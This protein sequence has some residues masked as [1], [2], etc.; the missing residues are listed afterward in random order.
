MLGNICN[1]CNKAQP[2]TSY[3]SSKLD[4]RMVSWLYDD[5]CYC[6]SK[7]QVASLSFGPF[8]AYLFSSDNELNLPLATGLKCRYWG[9][10]SGQT[11]RD[12]TKWTK[13]NHMGS[14][15]QHARKPQS[16]TSSKLPPTDRPSDRLTG[17]KCRATSVAK[18]WTQNS[19]YEFIKCRYRGKSP[20]QTG[21]NLTQW[22]EGWVDQTQSYG[23]SDS[24]RDTQGS[25]NP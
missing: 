11:G 23:I 4:L 13:H 14:L 10:S 25:Y 8:Q 5:Q 1:I 3:L 18:N 7:Y 21:P 24:K 17:V 19:F 2:V 6:L 12:L 22:P 16:Y 15:I 20:G 9:K